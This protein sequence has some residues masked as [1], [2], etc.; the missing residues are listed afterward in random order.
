MWFLNIRYKFLIRIVLVV[1]DVADR[2]REEDYAEINN[3]TLLIILTNFFFCL[4][5]SQTIKS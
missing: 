5:V 2:G 4:S 3:R 1:A